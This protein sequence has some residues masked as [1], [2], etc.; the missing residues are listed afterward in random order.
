MPSQAPSD[1][2]VFVR[3]RG[4]WKLALRIATGAPDPDPAV[5]ASITEAYANLY[6]SGQLAILPTPQTRRRVVAM[7]WDGATTLRELAP[8]DPDPTPDELDQLANAAR[9]WNDGQLPTLRILEAATIPG[10]TPT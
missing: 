7:L 1:R 6:G 3:V 9:G 4:R 5:L 2:A 8:G 10:R